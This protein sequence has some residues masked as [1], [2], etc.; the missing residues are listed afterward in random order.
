MPQLKLKTIWK[1]NE[2]EQQVFE[3]LRKKAEV[4]KQ[5]IL[6]Q[7]DAIK[8]FDSMPAMQKGGGKVICTW[9]YKQYPR[10]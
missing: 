5:K 8:V 10:T 9:K 1:N 2:N 6:S 7:D 3:R 4:E